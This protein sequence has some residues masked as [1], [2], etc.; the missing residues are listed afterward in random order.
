MGVVALIGV[1][2]LVFG[3]ILYARAVQIK[4]KAEEAEASIDV[5]LQKRADLIPNV[6]T[7]AKKFMEHE[8]TVLEELTAARAAVQ[9]AGTVQDKIRTESAVSGALG[10]FFAVAE[11]YPDLKSDGPMM[12]AQETY[13][14]VEA[15]IAAA[16][17]FYNAAVNEVN[18][19]VETWPQSIFTKMV[20]CHRLEYFEATAEA[21]KP[22]N[23]ADYL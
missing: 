1:G 7:I 10:R 18:T 2:L 12:T 14:E 21:K 9:S 4:N 22:V 5:Q 13:Q 23:A 6:L 8:K 19:A 20:S 3:Y 15:Q 17:R 16:R 11:N